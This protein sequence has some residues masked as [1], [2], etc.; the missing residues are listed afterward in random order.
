MQNPEPFSP[1]D[2]AG[3]ADRDPDPWGW[4]DDHPYDDEEPQS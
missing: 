2:F 3:M 4:A 1:E